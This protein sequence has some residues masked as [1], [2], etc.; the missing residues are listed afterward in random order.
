RFR[1]ERRRAPRLRGWGSGRPAPPRGERRLRDLPERLA[2]ALGRGSDR[3]ELRNGALTSI[4]ERRHLERDRPERG[5]DLERAALEL[6]TLLLAYAHAERRGMDQH[7]ARERFG[8]R[9]IRD[10]DE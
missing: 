6:V 2:G 5:V 1:A 8:P 4:G 9:G 7:Q 3:F 10:H